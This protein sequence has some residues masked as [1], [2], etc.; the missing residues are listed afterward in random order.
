[1]PVFEDELTHPRE[2][3]R[4]CLLLLLAEEPGHGYDLMMRL[5]P[6]G[7]NWGGPGPIYRELRI[8]ED[9]GAVRSSWE[10]PGAGPARHVYELT[11]VGAV[12]LT[13]WAGDLHNLSRLLDDYHGRFHALREPCPE[14]DGRADL[15]GDRSGADGAG[16]APGHDGPDE[17]E[18][19]EERG[20]PG[21][22]VA[23][24]AASGGRAGSQGVRIRRR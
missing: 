12:T 4:P 20:G 6:F 23:L 18:E 24:R 15:D 8:L 5:K 14:R 2:L 19:P 21:A 10:A 9:S 17:P 7:F 3:L 22:P 1:M 13:R 11:P 16:S